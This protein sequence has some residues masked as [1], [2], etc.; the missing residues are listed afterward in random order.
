MALLFTIKHNADKL[1]EQHCREAVDPTWMAT[2]VVFQVEGLKDYFLL[3]HGSK[4]GKI[5]TKK[6]VVSL[7]SLTPLF[8]NKGI[9]S[10]W[11][12]CCHPEAFP[13]SVI[14]GVEFKHLAHEVPEEINQVGKI[15][16]Y[17]GKTLDGEVTLEIY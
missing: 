3:A 13:A 2:P 8:L 15:K 17:I 7:E 5:Y 1:W 16:T 14:N 4:D 11:L 6:G 12:V 9:D 10:V